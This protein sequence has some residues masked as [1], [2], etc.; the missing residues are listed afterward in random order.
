MT[1]QVLLYH[2][3]YADRLEIAG[4]PAREYVPMEEF[5]AHILWLKEAGY[6]L[7]TLRECRTR[8]ERGGLPPRSVCLTFDDGK[9]SDLRL[10]APVL[11]D[12][13]ARATFF[14]IPGWLG[15]PNILTAD[16]VKELSGAGFEIGAHSLNHPFLTSLGDEA[17]RQEVRAPKSY[18]E[19][20]LGH[21]VESFSYPFG[22]SDRRVRSAVA[23]AGHHGCPWPCV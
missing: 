23:E 6:A 1:F 3:L 22:D 9:A 20:L 10:A 5:R 19:D 18:L 21:Q 4:K 8:V 2:G 16:G 13:G 7:L 17:L 15:K 11:A 14:I 12:L